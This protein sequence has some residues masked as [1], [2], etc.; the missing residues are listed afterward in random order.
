MTKEKMSAANP[1]STIQVTLMTKMTLDQVKEM[2]H[3]ETYDEAIG[4]LIREQKK[5]M[6]SSAGKFPSGGPFKRDEEEDPYRV[7]S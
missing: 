5:T 7:P 3:L 1:K 2:K 4:F 6:P